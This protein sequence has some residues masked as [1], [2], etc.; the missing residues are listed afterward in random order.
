MNVIPFVSGIVLC[1]L[2]LTGGRAEART[3]RVPGDFTTLGAA[4]AEIASGDTI[5]VAP[6]EY[7]GPNNRD[8]LVREKEFVLRSE[9]GAEQTIVDLAREPET[10]A[11]QLELQTRATLI[12]GFTFRRSSE[13]SA[14]ILR[15]SGPIV[16]NCVFVENEAEQGGAL[17]IVGT[18]PVLIENCH[19]EGNAGGFGGAVYCGRLSLAEF[20]SCRF[21]GNSSS[22]GGGALCCWDRLDIGIRNCLFAGNEARDGGAIFVFP[23]GPETELTIEGCTFADNSATRLG[24]GI[25]YSG[26]SRTKL[27]VR[28][29]IFYRNAADHGQALHVDRFSFLPELWCCVVSQQEIIGTVDRFLSIDDDPL[30][31]LGKGRIEDRYR[32]Q[33]ISPCVPKRSLCGEQIGAFGVGC[34]AGGGGACCLAGGECEIR[35]LEEC[36]GV[37]Q[38]VG[39]PCDV[40]PCLPGGAC[41]LAEECVTSTIE[42]CEAVF[43]EFLGEGVNCT[44]AGCPPLACCLEDGTCKVLL[45]GDCVDIGGFGPY[46]TAACD[47]DPCLP[48]VLRVPSEFQTLESALAAASPRDTV[49]LAPGTYSG[50]SYRELTVDGNELVITS[51]QGPQA[52][53]LDC[54][55]RGRAFI[56]G[57]REDSRVRIDGLTIRNGRAF[58]IGGSKGM[59]GAILVTTGNNVISNCI[60]ED[61]FSSDL[62]GAVAALNTEL[63]IVDSDIR[64]NVAD[65]QIH[66]GNGGGI[67]A[68]ESLLDI[69]RTN[70]SANVGDSGGGIYA[71]ETDIRIVDCL[72]SGNFSRN[73]GGAMSLRRCSIQ[74]ER[75]TIAGNRASVRGGGILTNSSRG[76]RVFDSVIW[77]NGAR[78]GSEVY[79]GSVGGPDIFRCSVVYR[80]GLEGDRFSFGPDNH[81]RAP[82]YCDPMSPETAPTS[83]A[84]IPSPKTPFVWK[85]TTPVKP[86]WEQR[87]SVAA[88]SRSA[89]A[90]TGSRRNAI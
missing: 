31:C 38:G 53:I 80:P 37:F 36:D 83:G 51:E 84:T 27:S 39:R 17:H 34:E 43:G 89:P 55:G 29:S 21:V 2:V 81:F 64:G 42:H 68:D 15:S 19:F 59:G 76:T 79:F 26:R 49:R 54:G 7:S 14:L 12:D 48:R 70:M 77:G 62:G 35:T 32:L 82:L 58:S 5:L 69:R 60:L 20:E 72:L 52:T 6:G 8:I 86:G 65:R 46:P 45:P 87:A 50:S 10:S 1:L 11:L 85:P 13:S 23:N 74:V 33:S 24:G 22:D 78:F 25:R 9:K 56:V 71:E 47:P 40:E 28:R 88:R 30:F 18:T 66:S 67:Y 4:L 90:A 61:S 75:C 16:R 44:P 57:G 41:C 63:S 73:S 3:L